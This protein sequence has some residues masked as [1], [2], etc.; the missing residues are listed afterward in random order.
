[1]KKEEFLKR[2]EKNIEK[3]KKLMGEGNQERQERGIGNLIE[4]L[5]NIIS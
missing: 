5:I 4:K 2:K 1:M 3:Y